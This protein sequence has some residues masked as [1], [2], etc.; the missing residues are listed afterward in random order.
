[1]REER[2]FVTY[3]DTM[4]LIGKKPIE[5]PRNIKVT[6]ADFK[7]LVEGPKGKLEFR[8][9]FGIQ[10]EINESKVFVKR[11]SDNKFSKSLH[12]L[13]RSMIN[14]MII[15]VNS[16]YSK[17]LEIQGVGFRG[18]VQGKSLL[19]QLGFSHQIN[20]PIP[21]GI[22]IETPKPTNLI[23]K[24]IDKQRVGQ[25]A[26]EIRNFFTPEPYKGKGI[27]YAGEYVRKKVGKAVA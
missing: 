14:N 1:M 23:I 4:S 18:Q 19:L 10:V 7:V 21:E 27:R 12:G 5:I 8:I 26:A 20:Y 3:G 11:N 13:V 25:V 24:G 15:G 6:L 22:T 2:L 17:G 16:G 9:P